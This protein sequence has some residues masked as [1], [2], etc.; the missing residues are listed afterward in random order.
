ME[1]NR[2][3]EEDRR[4]NTDP[5]PSERM[6]DNAESI[7]LAPPLPP[8]DEKDDKTSSSPQSKNATIQSES[9][10]KD[11]GYGSMECFSNSQSNRR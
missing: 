3:G 8:N 6:G 1:V 9:S 4:I 11:Q 7:Q 5:G 10:Q 2:E